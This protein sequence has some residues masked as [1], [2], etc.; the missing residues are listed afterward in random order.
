VNLFCSTSIIVS[1]VL[2]GG[3]DRHHAQAQALRIMQKE[4]DFFELSESELMTD[5]YAVE[6]YSR[7][8]NGDHSI[9]K[10]F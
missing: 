10:P 5:R 1:D 3:P 8:Y 9:F 6:F 7:L 4:V 2:A